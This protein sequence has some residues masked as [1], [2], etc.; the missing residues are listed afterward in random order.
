MMESVRRWKAFGDGKR[1][2]MES[3]RRWKAFGDGKRSAMESVPTARP[4]MSPRGV[5]PS[6]VVVETINLGSSR[7]NKKPFEAS[8]QAQAGNPPDAQRETAPRPPAPPAPPRRASGGGRDSSP[9]RR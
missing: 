6:F 1:S 9:S 4:S 7:P 3:V 2:A 8:S 5:G